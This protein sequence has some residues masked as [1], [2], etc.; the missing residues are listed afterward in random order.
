MLPSG[1]PVPD[2]ALI[3]SFFFLLPFLSL[4]LGI[5]PNVFP[6]SL[7]EICMFVEDKNTNNAYKD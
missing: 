4:S 2:S 6:L 1:L 3:S 7:Q 5:S